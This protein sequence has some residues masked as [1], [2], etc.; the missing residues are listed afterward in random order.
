MKNLT[1]LI[2][3]AAFLTGCALP[4][5]PTTSVCDTAPPESYICTVCTRIGISPEKADLIL[6]AASL[7]FLDGDDARKALKFFDRVEDILDIE[8]SYFTL[9]KFVQKEVR[10][11]GPEM[12]IIS[13]YLP[14]FNSPSLISDFDKGLLY[15]HINHQRAL[16][17]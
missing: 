1:I 5:Y 17:Q 15:A 4:M 7:R 3:I 16:L 11:T 13:M 8:L 2:I 10:L 6:Q 9:I 14:Q 12:L